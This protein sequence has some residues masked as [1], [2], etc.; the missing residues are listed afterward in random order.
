MMMMMCNLRQC[1]GVY[2]AKVRIRLC[3]RY[4]PLSTAVSTSLRADDLDMHV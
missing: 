1:V 2:A 3:H 4:Q